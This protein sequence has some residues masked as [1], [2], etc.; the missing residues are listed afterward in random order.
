MQSSLWPG[1]QVRQAHSLLNSI[2]LE[3]P[4]AAVLSLL[5]QALP[6]LAPPTSTSHRLSSGFAEKT[7]AIRLEA[8]II[9]ATLKSLQ[10]SL[11]FLPTFYL[12]SEEKG[13]FLPLCMVTYLL[14]LG[15][16]LVPSPPGLTSSRKCSSM[17]AST[18]PA[19]LQ[20]SLL[21]RLKHPAIFDASP[22][23]LTLPNE[24]GEEDS[25]QASQGTYRLHQPGGGQNFHRT[26]RHS[27][28]W[29]EIKK[30]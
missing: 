18:P 24:G 12:I 19:S 3:F 27:R 28:G 4:T 8:S 10:A 29:N 6:T 5:L 20:P 26:D 16:H 25:L 7:K 17:T 23:P 21:L 1:R 2:P 9:L 15:S 13:L 14:G 11:S 30:I 22:S